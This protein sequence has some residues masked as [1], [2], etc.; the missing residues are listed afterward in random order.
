MIFNIDQ[1]YVSKQ[2]HNEIDTISHTQIHLKLA[3]KGCV[4]WLML[5]SAK[6]LMKTSKTSKK[7]VSI[8]ALFQILDVIRLGSFETIFEFTKGWN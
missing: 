1:Y 7:I 6:T 5:I 3:V 2:D 8:F 4:G